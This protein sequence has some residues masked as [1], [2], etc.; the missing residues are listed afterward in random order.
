MVDDEPPSVFDLSA[1]AG[2][3]DDALLAAVARAPSRTPEPPGLAPGTEVA[4]RFR[5]ERRIGAGGMGTVYLARDPVLRREVALKVHRA[6]AGTARLHREAVSMA[7]LSH[8]NVINVFEVGQVGDRLFVAM[9]YV[10]G[11]TLRAW[12]A[13]RPRPWREILAMVLAAG[14]GL[15]AAHDAGLVH[16]DFKPENVLVGTDG[17]ARVGDFGLARGLPDEADAGGARDPAGPSERASS[18]ELAATID[19]SREEVVAG[20][21]TLDASLTLTGAAVGTP[22]YM[23]PEQF[24]ASAAD[25][26]ADQFAFCVVA[27]E[28]LYGERPFVGETLGALRAA[29][30]AGALRDPPAARV[31][32]RLHRLIARG[33]AV[34]PAE[35][36]P[37]MRALLG[38]LR[39]VA[40]PGRG[41]AA[42]RAAALGGVL[43]VA[44]VGGAAWWATRPAATPSCARAPAT[45]STSCSPPASRVAAATAAGR[46]G[47]DDEARVAQQLATF[48]QGYRR[49]ARDACEARNVRRE[50]SDEL[51]A[52]SQA[53]LRVRALVAR[54][55][56]EALPAGAA[57]VPDFVRALAELPALPSC[58]DAVVLA[59]QPPPIRD[60]DRLA[61][62]SAARAALEGA[63]I[64]LS[65]GRRA[66]AQATVE[67]IAAEAL[68]DPTIDAILALA[69]GHLLHQGDELL[70]GERLVAD[71][72]YEARARGDGELAL[73]A[74]A[75]LIHSAGALRYDAAAA[76]AWIRA[77]LADAE[78]EQR[79]NPAGAASVLSAAGSVAEEQGDAALA[80]TRARRARELLGDD[81][82]AL[83]RAELLMGE[84]S[85]QVA[86]NA[87]AA[88]VTLYEQAL[89]LREAELGADHPLVGTTLAALSVALLE[90]NR[91]AE[92]ATIATRAR[93]LIAGAPES[94]GTDVA[95]AAHNLGVALLYAGDWQQAG[96]LLEDARRR[97]AAALGEDNPTVALC[98]ANLA[99]VYQAGGDLDG[100]L[101]ALARA[102]AGQERAFGPDHVKV[103]TT[104]YNLAAVQRARGELAA[105]RDAALRSAAIFA[106]TLHGHD[107]HLYAPRWRRWRR[108]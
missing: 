99:L 44:A 59:A 75:F 34:A 73:R 107:R 5:V 81:A 58:G 102:L 104:L 52:R 3:E 97:Y 26:R 38:A 78:A 101:G 41:R 43:V 96:P 94:S 95:T 39:A 45:S 72:Y 85:A 76:D 86:S 29:V 93:A 47:A 60:R 13:A 15:A 67:R 92:A 82:P 48:A 8:P 98:D 84:A 70:A 54:A 12:L 28:A 40:D 65:L 56:A 71:A 21:A 6:E 61:T 30:L 91:D 16:R 63:L 90:A 17:R 10:R 9:E 35:R 57:D 42:G 68:A 14:D 64:D 79:R 55:T 2:S 27:W 19:A 50:W 49:I 46:R 7:Q 77:G 33:L 18:S 105:S 69:R 1:S 83:K 74:V 108:T 106:R 66:R 24:G 80:A 36:H 25:A 32:A 51:V 20:A 100:A 31:P 87:A 11:T 22:A 103:G 4:G 88:G 89:A 53:C 62:V 37:D 23:A